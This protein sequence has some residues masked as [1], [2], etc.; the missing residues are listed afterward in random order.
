MDSSSIVEHTW[1]SVTVEARQGRF[2]LWAAVDTRTGVAVMAGFD[3]QNQ[4]IL[5]AAMHGHVFVRSD[6]ETLKEWD[7]LGNKA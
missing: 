5:W 7:R 4:V 1:A 2:G 3:T 6:A